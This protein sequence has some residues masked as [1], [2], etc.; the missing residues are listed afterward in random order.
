MKRSVVAVALT[1]ALA[2]FASS[3]VS[4]APKKG[5]SDEKKIEEIM[6]KG[7][8]KGTLLDKIKSHDAS[9]AELQQF[10]DYC[11]AL[12]SLKPPKGDQASWDS[13]TKLLADNAAAV[14]KGDDSKLNALLD[15]T[16]CKDCHNA[17]KGK[18]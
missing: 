10:A 18:G 6:K 13:K 8:K 14:A 4:A 16:N 3:M 17:H 1:A 9:K 11:K 12:V 5:S 7:F 2:V 15:A